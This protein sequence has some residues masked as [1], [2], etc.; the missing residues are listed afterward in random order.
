M[1]GRHRGKDFRAGRAGRRSVGTE[2]QVLVL[3]AEDRD[4]RRIVVGLERGDQRV[5]RGFGRGEGLLRG[6]GCRERNRQQQ[7]QCAHSEQRAKS[8]EVHARGRPVDCVGC[9]HGGIHVIEHGDLRLVP[10]RRRHGHRRHRPLGRRP[11]RPSSFGSTLRVNCRHARNCRNCSRRRRCHHR[12]P[13]DSH[14]RHRRPHDWHSRH[15]NYPAPTRWR[16]PR[17]MRHHCS[18]RRP[19]VV[20]RGVPCRRRR[21]HRPLLRPLL[22]PDSHHRRAMSS[23]GAPRRC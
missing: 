19:Q 4:Q 20:P 6:C 8:C 3:F 2:D 14:S 21:T 17:A 15:R 18:S 7:G 22:R 5:D 9:I 23:T 13:R 11:R 10:R 16:F 1:E 12:R